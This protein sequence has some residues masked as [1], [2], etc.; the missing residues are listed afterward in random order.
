MAPARRTKSS[1]MRNAQIDQQFASDRV[2]PT[3]NLHKKAP[4]L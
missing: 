3:R 4:S 2:F 1:R